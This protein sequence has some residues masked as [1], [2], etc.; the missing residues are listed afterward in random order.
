[1]VSQITSTPSLY[2][3]TKSWILWDQKW[4]QT[5]GVPLAI[6]SLFQ[7]CQYTYMPPTAAGFPS[8]SK[9]HNCCSIT[10]SSSLTTFFPP[11][12]WPLF[13]AQR[14]TC[15]PFGSTR[16]CWKSLRILCNGG[17]PISPSTANSLHLLF[18]ISI[19]GYLSWVVKCSMSSLIG[20]VIILEMCKRFSPWLEGGIFLGFHHLF[21]I[22]ARGWDGVH[23]RKSFCRA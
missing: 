3:N 1:M 9:V 15:L 13:G 7:C 11:P 18:R 14:L 17:H 2:I 4:L 19:G 22:S 10:S 6:S 5:P 23:T 21:Y 8:A 20:K 16:P 12:G